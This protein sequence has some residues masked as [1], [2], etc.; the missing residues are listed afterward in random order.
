MNN[1]K[2]IVEISGFGKDTGYEK[3]CQKMLQQGWDWLQEHPKANIKTHT[4]SNIYGILECDNEDAKALSDAVTKDTDCTGAMHQAVMQ[5]LIYI[6]NNGLDK[7]K[8][9]VKKK[10]S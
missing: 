4:Y 7:W 10:S 6:H 5:H 3:E 2:G 9:E 8:L 1:I